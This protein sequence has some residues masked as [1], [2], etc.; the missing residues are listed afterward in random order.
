ML[1]SVRASGGDPKLM[2]A[3][4]DSAAQAYIGEQLA[5]RYPFDAVLSEEAADDSDRLTH[6]RVRIIDPLD[7][8]REFSEPP[9][10]GCDSVLNIG[11]A[12]TVRPNWAHVGETFASNRDEM[13][14][15][16]G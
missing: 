11:F 10:V 6:R 14:L 13:R 3:M 8:T 4:G 15:K 16:G 2:R 7:G 5:N 1:L 9:R 12:D